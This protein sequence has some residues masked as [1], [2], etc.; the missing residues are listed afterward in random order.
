MSRVIKFRVFYDGRWYQPVL[1]GGTQV[2]QVFNKNCDLVNL[3]TTDEEYHVVQFTG[4]LDKNGKEIYEGDICRVWEYDNF[5]VKTRHETNK[6][7]IIK[8]SSIRPQ[9]N[10]FNGERLEVIGNI[11]EN[12][13]LIK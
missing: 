3:C 12:K 4:L 5:R 6:L 7:Q 1:V 13:E 11:Y 9:F 2:P 8:W 10:F